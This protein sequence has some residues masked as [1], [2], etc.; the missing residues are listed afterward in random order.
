[1]WFIGV[2]LEMGWVGCL[3][4]RCDDTQCYLRV[5]LD[6]LGSGLSS[7]AC[8]QLSKLLCESSS[9]CVFMY[10]AHAFFSL[11][12]NFAGVP[13]SM[14]AFGAEELL[15]LGT[16]CSWSADE[17]IPGLFCLDN[18]AIPGLF[19]LDNGAGLFIRGGVLVVIPGMILYSLEETES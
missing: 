6:L 18:G 5:E 12:W 15:R 17:P 13:E 1:V 4:G 3:G 8:F 9:L 19:C 7:R 10:F 14:R 11:S 16:Y 2:F